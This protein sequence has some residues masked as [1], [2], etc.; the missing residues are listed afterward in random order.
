MRSYEALNK[1]V[2]RSAYTRRIME[3]VKSIQKQDTTIR[4][5]LVDTRA[6]QKDINQLSE[7]LERTFFVTDELIFRDAKKDDAVRASYKQLAAL[8]EVR[9]LGRCWASGWRGREAAAG[10]TGATRAR[11]RRTPAR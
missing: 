10:L 1:E 3:I 8:H 4:Q 5:V 11:G 9:L 2:T 6:L 7:K